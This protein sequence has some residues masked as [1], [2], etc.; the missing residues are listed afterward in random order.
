[1]PSPLPFD[2]SAVLIKMVHSMDFVV[3]RL[4]IVVPSLFLFLSLTIPLSGKTRAIADVAVDRDYVSA[5]AAV[6]RFLHAW[7]TDD[8]E[9]GILMLTDK[10][11]QRSNEETVREFFSADPLRAS[12]EIGRGR[13]LS[14]GH[15]EFPVTLFQS[16]SQNGP[17]WMHPQSSALIVV[18]A[19]KTDWAIDKLP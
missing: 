5:L 4:R 10:L 11:K 8:E 18:K 7:Q 12:Y 15:Y 6:D 1:M 2:T 9:A 14:S 19:G 17:H 13:K 3:R 16:P